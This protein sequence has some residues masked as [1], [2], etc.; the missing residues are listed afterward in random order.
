MHAQPRPYHVKDGCKTTEFWIALLVVAVATVI[1]GVQVREHGINNSSAVAVASAA[2]TSFG[3]ARA[4][5][6]VKSGH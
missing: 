4:R 2:L 1:V 5:A 6:L 3:Y